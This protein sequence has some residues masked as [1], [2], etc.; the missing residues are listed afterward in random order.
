MRAVFPSAP[1]ELLRNWQITFNDARDGLQL[2]GAGVELL[3][4]PRDAVGNQV[5][6]RG[7]FTAHFYSKDNRRDTQLNASFTAVVQRTTA[8]W[9][10]V[11]IR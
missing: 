3:D 8:G 5:H 6:A 4:S 7:Q 9:R 2:R 11:S 1:G 10:I